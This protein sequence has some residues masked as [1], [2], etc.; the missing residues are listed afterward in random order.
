MPRGVPLSRSSAQLRRSGTARRTT[1]HRPKADILGRSVT[2]SPSGPWM[3]G[4]SG[5]PVCAM[6]QVATRAARDHR[7]STAP[8]R[9]RHADRWTSTGNLLGSSH[10]STPLWPAS[11]LSPKLEGENDYPT[12]LLSFPR[13]RPPGYTI[14]RQSQAKPGGSNLRGLWIP[15][16][17]PPSRG[18][19]RNDGFASTRL[20]S[21]AC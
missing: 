21:A 9:V 3:I 16:L 2:S 14:F 4:D 19:G 17:P 12:P 6:S 11:I 1:A 10:G 13:K 18:C 20:F 8:C 5:S 7:G 15:A